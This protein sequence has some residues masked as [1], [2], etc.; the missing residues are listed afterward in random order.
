MG[1]QQLHDVIDNTIAA[2]DL[3]LPARRAPRS[4]QPRLDFVTPR[5]IDGIRLGYAGLLESGRNRQP[6]FLDA[7]AE[8]KGET[9]TDSPGIL[10]KQ[11]VV[12]IDRLFRQDGGKVRHRGVAI[13]ASAQWCSTD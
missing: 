5:E 10:H 12:P 7:D 11:R 13:L 3:H 6:L 9:V 2:E 4:S 8:V 1:E